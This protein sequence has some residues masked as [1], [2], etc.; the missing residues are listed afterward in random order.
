MMEKLQYHDVFKTINVPKSERRLAMKAKNLL[1]DANGLNDPNPE[2]FQHLSKVTNQESGAQAF[3]DFENDAEAAYDRFAITVMGHGL[4]LA[5][6]HR[7]FDVARTTF[8]ASMHIEN[9][10]SVVYAA[11]RHNVDKV[12]EAQFIDTV[13]NI[14]LYSRV[15][16]LRQ[17]ESSEASFANAA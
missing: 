2:I 3:W 15:Q 4:T 16:A 14:G 9:G 6:E 13:A 7:K 1:D 11:E 12:F 17:N 10:R 8:R 5:I